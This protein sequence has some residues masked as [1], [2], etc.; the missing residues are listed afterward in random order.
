MKIKEAVSELN[1]LDTID[2]LL[3]HGDILV[4]QAGNPQSNWFLKIGVK[5]KDWRDVGK[6]YDYV[7]GL[8]LTDFINA[9]NVVQQLLDTPIEDRFPEKK[10]YLKATR[11]YVGPIPETHYVGK[12][13]CCGDYSKV[14]YTSEPTPFTETELQN[15]VK[16]DPALKGIVDDLKVPVE[17]DK[18]ED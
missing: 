3:L 5:D 13:E 15:V 18:N 1:E 8:G 10:Y 11:Y 14:I 9:L 4:S 17:D 6:D 2:A 7:Y 12:F 16:N